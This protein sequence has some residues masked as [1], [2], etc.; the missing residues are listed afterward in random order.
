VRR[1]AERGVLHPVE[2]CERPDGGVDVAGTQNMPKTAGKKKW[3]SLR[4]QEDATGDPDGQDAGQ[5]GPADAA[6]SPDAGTEK[7]VTR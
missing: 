2:G 6:S 4:R 3:W 5:D 1:V 7:E